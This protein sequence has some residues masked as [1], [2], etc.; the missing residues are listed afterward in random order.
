MR[1]ASNT[2]TSEL[3][4]SAVAPA[5]PLTTTSGTSLKPLEASAFEISMPA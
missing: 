3:P 2:L 5:P 1:F 4:P